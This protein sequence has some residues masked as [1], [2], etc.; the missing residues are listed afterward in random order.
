MLGSRYG[1]T[2]YNVNFDNNRWKWHLAI[3][4]CDGEEGGGGKFSEGPFSSAGNPFERRTRRS[5]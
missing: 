1:T 3:T 5:Q 4:T 2:F